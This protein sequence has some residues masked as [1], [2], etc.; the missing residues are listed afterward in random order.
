M[1]F[2]QGFCQ[3]PDILGECIQDA[4][5]HRGGEIL[6]AEKLR[7]DGAEERLVMTVA[8]PLLFGI[9]PE[10]DTLKSAIEVGGGFLHKI[11]GEWY[12]Y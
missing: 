1:R 4:V 10:M 7:K 12:I 8:I 6:E 2:V 5:L 11:Y 3:S 9:P